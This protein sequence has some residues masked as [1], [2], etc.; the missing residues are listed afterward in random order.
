MS[1]NVGDPVELYADIMSHVGHDIEVVSYADGENAA[2]ECVE[3]GAVLIDADRP[4]R[5]Y[6]RPWESP[7]DFPGAVSWE[8]A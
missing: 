7:E 5:R 6:L 1:I 4:D 2:I 3:C 8:G